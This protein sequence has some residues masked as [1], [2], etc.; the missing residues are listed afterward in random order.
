MEE[1]VREAPRVSTIRK[2]QVS[3]VFVCFLLSICLSSAPLFSW[4]ILR[5][6]IH[7]N[8]YSYILIN[9]QVADNKLAAPK[10]V[11]A[12]EYKK[13]PAVQAEQTVA[14]PPAPSPPPPEPVKVEPVVT[15]QP[16]LLVSFF[17]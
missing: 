12:I 16:D 7:L 8:S 5:C 17:C 2:E 14:S 6:K 9:K 3:L 10:E 4:L 1:Y 11:L 13:E 15:E